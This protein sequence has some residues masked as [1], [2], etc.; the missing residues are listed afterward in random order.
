MNCNTP[1]RLSFRQ[2]IVSYFIAFLDEKVNAIAMIIMFIKFPFHA[3]TNIKSM[4]LVDG[5]FTYEM[6]D[7]AEKH[8]FG[9][10]Q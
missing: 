2:K 10:S 4:V 5:M 8:S 7:E 6:S 9:F 1:M 3:N